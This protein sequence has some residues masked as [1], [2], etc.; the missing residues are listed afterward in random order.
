[1]WS[2][3]ELGPPSGFHVSGE[4]ADGSSCLRTGRPAG[5]GAGLAGPPPP[6]CF[7]LVAPRLLDLLGPGAEAGRAGAPRPR[8]VRIPDRT[9]NIKHTF[10]FISQVVSLSKAG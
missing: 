1:M 5:G 2:S 9:L 6:W 3:E 8:A 10:L 7:G 4:Q